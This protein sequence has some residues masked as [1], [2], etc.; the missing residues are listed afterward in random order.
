VV[1]AN[2][3]LKDVFTILMATYYILNIGYPK[4]YAGVFGTLQ[5]FF[6]SDK[7]YRLWKSTRYHTLMSHLRAAT[8]KV[9]AAPNEDDKEL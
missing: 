5:T 1:E 7:P 9:L 8:E 6:L 4:Y 3:H 2:R